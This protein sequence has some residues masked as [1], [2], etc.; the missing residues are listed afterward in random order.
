MT[1]VSKDALWK[2]IIEDLFDDFLWYFFPN[3]AAREVDFSKKPVFLDK[4][5]EDLFPEQEN[6]QA[7]RADKLAKVFTKSGEE[8]WVLIHIEVQGY[9]DDDFAKRMFTYFYRI[10]DRNKKEIMA[11]AIFTENN[12]GYQPNEYIYQYENTKNVYQYDTFKLL[13]KTEDELNL[14][15]NPFSIVMLTAKKALL[16]K[17]LKDTQQLI[18]KKELVLALKAANYGTEKIRKI[19]NFIYFYVKFDE[20]DNF[21]IFDKEVEIILEQRKNMGIEEAILQDVK[22]QGIQQGITLNTIKGIQ[23]A[24]SR[25]KL[26]L[27]EIADLF[28]VSLKYVSEVK[29]GKIK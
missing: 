18:W 2:G 5:L 3:W 8:K 7:R 16:K 21:N 23:K 25:G 4:E 27:E 22:E 20:R 24:I 17:N 28:E 12:K 1:K 26:T 9:K 6:N 10:L 29:N 15:N 19:L 11:L 14:K 13:D